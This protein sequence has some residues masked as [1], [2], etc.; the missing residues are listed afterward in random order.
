MTTLYMQTTYLHVWVAADAVV[1]DASA[2]SA[3]TAST[4]AASGDVIAFNMVNV[5]I[6]IIITDIY[7]ARR[8]KCHS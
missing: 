8:M 4:V 1:V 3:H 5:I 7:I 6:I 2:A